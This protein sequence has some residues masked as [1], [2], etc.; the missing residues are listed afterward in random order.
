MTAE[1]FRDWLERYLRPQE[2]SDPEAVPELFANDGV[3]WWGPY[4]EPRNGAEAIY[5]HH[6]NALSH[7]EEI[8]YSYEILATTEE[9]GLAKVNLTLKDLTPNSPGEYE[10]IFKVYLNSE[11]K[12]TLFQEW[13]MWPGQQ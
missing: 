4:S 7:Q 3:Y 11:N 10:C 9:Y 12:C 2:N 1:I 5:A 8:K 6:K 13:C